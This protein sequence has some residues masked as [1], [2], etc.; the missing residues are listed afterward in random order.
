[1]NIEDRLKS[2]IPDSQFAAGKKEIVLRCPYC[3]HTS[4]PGKKHMYI[5][6]SKDKP[7]M[8][9][10]FKCEAGGLV[11][12]NFLELL[13]IKDLSLISKIEEYNKKMLKSKPKAYSSISTDERIIKYKDFVL[14]DRIYQEKVDYVNSRLGVV[15]PVWYLLELKI[16]FDFTFFRRQIMQVLGATESDYEQIQREY[17]GFLSINNTALIMRCIRPVDK[18][19]RYLIVK[20]SENNFTKTYSIPAQIPI[21]TD[22]VLV[23][24]TEGQFDILSVFTNLSY[25]A[26]G[27]YMAASGNK[28][29]NVI[30]LI[31]SRGIMNMDLHLYF[32]N[33]DAGDISMRQSEFFINN[34]IQFFRGS[35][36]YFHRNESGEKDYGVPLSKIKDSVRQ[37]L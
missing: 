21:T 29:P 14:D 36:V 32:D 27:I 28:Y 37:I 16:I 15:L 2:A 30:S 11:N 17:V 8:Y 4:S 24:I 12:R 34:N 6:V 13:K 9:N 7:I 10:C 18:K 23:N 26:N 31:L 1:M 20:L 22:K 35:S 33:D 3:G 25:G 19:F 5:G